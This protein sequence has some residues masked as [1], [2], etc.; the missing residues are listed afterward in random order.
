MPARSSGSVA[1]PILS[2]RQIPLF[3]LRTRKRLQYFDTV[4][5]TGAANA[6]ASY[7]VSANGAYDPDVTG[8]GHQPMGFDQMMVFYNH[9]TVMNARVRAVFQNIGAVSAHV[10]MSVSGTTVTISDSRQ[11]I[12]NG[13]VIYAVV[14]PTGIA[15]SIA[16]LRSSAS[17]ANFQGIQQPLDDPN[18][19]GDAA[20]NPTEQFYF[21]FH[22][23]NPVSATVPSVL[24][25]FYLEY[26]VVFHEPRKGSLSLT[27]FQL[28][29]NV[30]VSGS[31][32]ELKCAQP[33]RRYITPV[34]LR[35]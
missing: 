35:R 6:V 2:V 1:N 17:S 24:I 32:A 16:T 9:Y 31:S 34:L 3:G 33:L 26:D 14:T 25:D 27:D 5:F 10:G 4:L 8:T 11:L 23:W 22:V 12:E 28:P 15:D 18:M 21:H 7:V 30:S 13:E 20:S 19:R 29:D